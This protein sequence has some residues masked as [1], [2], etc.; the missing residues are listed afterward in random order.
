MVTYYDY[1]TSLLV[2]PWETFSGIQIPDKNSSQQLGSFWEI[3]PLYSKYKGS[4]DRHP[5]YVS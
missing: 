4:A 5:Y 1:V 3:I 2:T